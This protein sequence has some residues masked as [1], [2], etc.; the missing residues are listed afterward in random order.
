M[1]LPQIPWEQLGGP[2][3][4]PAVGSVVFGVLSLV[5]PAH[6]YGAAALVSALMMTVGHFVWISDCAPWWWEAVAYVGF[7]GAGWRLRLIR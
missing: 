2:L 4:L 7:F 6:L 3:A 5:R 1:E